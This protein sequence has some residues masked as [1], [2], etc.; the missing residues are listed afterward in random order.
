MTMKEFALAVAGILFLINCL[1]LSA[2]E[3][4]DLFAWSIIISGLI[5][6]MLYFGGDNNKIEPW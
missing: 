1:L 6:A 5:V 2:S 3:R 4:Y